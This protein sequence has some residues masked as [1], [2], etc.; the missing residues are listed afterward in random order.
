VSNS[1]LYRPLSNTTRN[2]SPVK[3]EK[4]GSPP[5]G[6]KNSGYTLATTPALDRSVIRKELDRG[7][8]YSRV[9]PIINEIREKDFTSRFVKEANRVGDILYHQTQFDEDVR[10]LTR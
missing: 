5:K 3:V 2:E 7:E 4:L 1:N 6:Y 10:H 8:E 9:K